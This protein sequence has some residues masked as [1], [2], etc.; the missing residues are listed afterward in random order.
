MLYPDEESSILEFKES[1]PQNHQ[2]IK[3][4]VGFCNR[5]GGKIV[6]GVKDDRTIVG[7]SE[8]AIQEA[9]DTLDQAIFGATSPPII[10]HIS[11]QHIGDKMILIVEVSSG[12]NKP[13]IV[14][15][16]GIE[17]GTYI[18]LGRS[19]LRANAG[20]IEE[21]KWQSRG[22]SM[23]SMPVYHAKEEDLDWNSI[24]SF[25]KWDQDQQIPKEILLAY[26]IFAEEHGLYYPTTA[27]ILLF[28]KKPQNFF[29][30]A[31]IIASHFSGIS[32]REALAS[33]DCEGTLF[34]QYRDAY[35]F[36]VSRLPH[37]FTIK[38]PLRQETLEL[39]AEAIREILLN[40]IVHRNY[41]LPGPTKVSI[42]DN[43]MEFFSPGD[44]PGPLNPKNL[45]SGLTYIRNPIICTMFRKA[46][47]IEKMGT[48]LITLF[49]SFEL[50]GLK[51][52]EV[53]EGENFV[54]CILPREMSKHIE[55][56][57]SPD[58]QKIVDLIEQVEAVTISD[59]MS[60]LNQPRTTIYRKLN[61]LVK[62]G[63][64]IRIGVRKGTKYIS[65][66]ITT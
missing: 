31:M 47:L 56:S 33:I 64:V 27:S 44:F 50:R 38:G 7:L 32:G 60:L 24:R 9:M 36:L 37:A 29:S 16:E 12:M 3:T 43:R 55:Q 65:K 25:I 42:Y 20:M 14:K 57:L 51:S 10:P 13:Y 11:F 28:G 61:E 5:K 4:I 58:L 54:K 8:A 39:P 6:I 15:S 46:K 45:R 48:G 62:T 23:D 41:H 30:E 34:Q 2:I 26:H 52:P 49:D 59:I 22:K 19:T 66:K 40:A 21:L 53:M 63:K 35:H 17:K 1:F 18:R